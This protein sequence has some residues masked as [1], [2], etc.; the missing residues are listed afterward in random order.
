MKTMILYFKLLLSFGLMAIFFQGCYTQFVPTRD[1]DLSYRQEQQSA[2]QND[3]SYYGEDNDNWQ[4]HQCLGFSYYYPGWNSYWSWDYGC[5][6][7]S[8]WD[9]WSLGSC[10]LYWLFL[11]S[12]LLGLQELL[13]RVRLWLSSIVCDAQF[14]LSEK[15]K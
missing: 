1:E 3:S 9:P 10:I 13:F 12:S 15:W 2:V 8:Y 14:W 7:P 11:L 4:S 5:V 6:Y